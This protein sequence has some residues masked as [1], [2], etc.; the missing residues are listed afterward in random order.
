MNKPTVTSRTKR[1]RVSN[2]Y[3]SLFY[4]LFFITLWSV[5]EA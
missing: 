3:N 2:L 4:K 1:E 5:F